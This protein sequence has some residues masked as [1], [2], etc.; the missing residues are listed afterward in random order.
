MVE[1]QKYCAIMTDK[2][3]GSMG[4]PLKVEVNGEPVFL[5]CKGCKAKALRDADATL[6][7]V[8]K[9]RSENGEK[10]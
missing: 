9:L 1:S 6:A 7:T 10:R 8:A 2:L 5:C 4:T 3:L